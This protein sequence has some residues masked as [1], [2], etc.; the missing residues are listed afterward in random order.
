MRNNSTKK[1]PPYLLQMP[2]WK[3]FIFLAKLELKKQIV[4]QLF[5]IL[6]GPYT[7]VF[8]SDYENGLISFFS[9]SKKP[10]FLCVSI[11]LLL[12]SFL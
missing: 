11:K 1:I 3:Q 12:L 10:L 8:S 5:Y 7:L 2:K 4:F 9:H 6:T